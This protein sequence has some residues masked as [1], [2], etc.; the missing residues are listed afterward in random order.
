MVSPVELSIT[1]PTNRS[2]AFEYSQ[3]FSVEQLAV[4]G[5]VSGVCK[6]FIIKGVIL[7]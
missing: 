6:L 7:V 5:V 1:E 3:R 4:L 2:G